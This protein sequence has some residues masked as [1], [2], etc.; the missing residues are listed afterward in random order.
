MN[1]V[2][3]GKAPAGKE[4]VGT[5]PVTPR[6]GPGTVPAAVEPRLMA[7]SLVGLSVRITGDV[8]CRQDLFVEGEVEGTVELPAHKLTVGPRGNVKATIKAHDVVIVG[9]VEGTIEASERVELCSQGRFVGDVRTPRIVIKDGAHFRGSIEVTR[10]RRA[11]AVA[12]DASAPANGNP[13][14]GNPLNGN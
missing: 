9:K 8:F 3:L 14:N 7:A 5:A 1:A 11:V 12:R 4:P 10:E 2:M 6:E 13:L